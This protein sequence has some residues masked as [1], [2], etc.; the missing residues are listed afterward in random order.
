MN[1]SLTRTL[2]DSDAWIGAI[3]TGV[4]FFLIVVGIAA[5]HKQ[6]IGYLYCYATLVGF[7]EMLA[8]AHILAICGLIVL[9]PTL[10]NAA[11]VI[12][13]R[14]MDNP[15]DAMKIVMSALYGA[16]WCGWC[17][18]LI[19]LVSLRLAARE[20]I[21]GHDVQEPKRQHSIE[22]S[23]NHVSYSNSLMS[24]HLFN[25]RQSVI[26]PVGGI[27]SS[28]GPIISRSGVEIPSSVGTESNGGG[29]GPSGSRIYKGKEPIHRRHCDE[30][31]M[32][33]I[34]DRAWMGTE[35][36]SPLDTSTIYIPNNPRISQVV[37]TF[38][39]DSKE[40]HSVQQGPLQ[41]GSH[42]VRLSQQLHGSMTGDTAPSRSATKAS[43]NAGQ[44]YDPNAAAVAA[45][46]G[47][48]S[49][50]V[51]SSGGIFVLNISPSGESLSEMIFSPPPTAN[52][53]TSPPQTMPSAD[54]VKRSSEAVMVQDGSGSNVCG[55][56]VP[57]P[58]RTRGT[59]AEVLLTLSSD[60]SSSGLSAL[61][62]ATSSDSDGPGQL[63]ASKTPLE[64]SNP[65]GQDN[66]ITSLAMVSAMPLNAVPKANSSST[67][68]GV[69]DMTSQAT[70]SRDTPDQGTKSASSCSE[71]HKAEQANPQ[72]IPS[73]P[74]EQ[75]T[76][77]Q[78]QAFDPYD[79][80]EDLDELALQTQPNSSDSSPSLSS[81][82]SLPL[83]PRRQSYQEVRPWRRNDNNTSTAAELLREDDME[84]AEQILIS[85]IS[86]ASLALS[87]SSASA[88][89]PFHSPTTATVMASG[90][91]PQPSP[92]NAISALVTRPKPS[93]VS[94]PLQYW[95]NRKNAQ[96]LIHQAESSVSSLFTQ[97]YL[98][99]TF[100][101]KKKM[102]IPTIV[103]HPDEEDGEP[104]RVLSQKDIDYLSTMPP[105]PLRRLI[106]P[107]D[108]I[109]EEDGY[110]DECG[111][112]DYLPHHRESH[113][114]LI[115]GLGRI[116]EEDEGVEEDGSADLEG[117]ACT[118][119]ND[120]RD[121]VVDPYAFDVP[122]DFE[123]DLQELT[124]SNSPSLTNY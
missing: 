24:Q 6:R 44:G 79:G 97:N 121:R 60:S 57:N 69:A 61:S 54:S 7:W 114:D 109:P 53:P 64:M 84:E 51:R 63:A 101:K 77:I 113:H 90:Q 12:G 105:P 80:A 30:S 117:F 111:P 26:S 106:Q 107:W 28:T 115:G 27:A 18:T 47:P 45:G 78:S 65:L 70:S 19:C 4:G 91:P 99:N 94:F 68:T 2:K 37:V 71:T 103:I 52:P 108:D 56:D 83:S 21:V 3:I 85:M 34:S 15:S 67:E 9:P 32:C 72:F 98:S 46:V 14:I 92:S 40:G 88:P 112:D 122:I 16:Q 74:E 119:M 23:R 1:T 66:V 62:H 10:V 29:G 59:A 116:E 95:R 13:Q 76:A 75:G 96:P 20:L 58:A 81:L 86:K 38:R 93:L 55:N 35:G 11:N 49:S 87:S 36:T 124:H 110:E 31:D 17:I 41:Q 22:T 48:S 82:S 42:P 8:L 43:F 39:D 89:S 100:S 118:E 25:F 102:I 5:A 33:R 50:N 104:P 120:R 73:I 123:I